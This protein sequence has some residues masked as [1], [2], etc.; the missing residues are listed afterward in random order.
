MAIGFKNI[1]RTPLGDPLFYDNRGFMF[2]KTPYACIR[3]WTN[4]KANLWMREWGR[5]K[6]AYEDTWISNTKRNIPHVK[7]TIPLGRPYRPGPHDGETC[8]LV[9]N[10][11][12]LR[13]NWQLLRG[14]DNIIGTNRIGL[15]DGVVPKY[16]MAIDCGVPSSGANPEW[17][18]SICDKCIGVFS[19]F[20][21][22]EMAAKFQRKWWF[23]AWG[24]N[25]ELSTKLFKKVKFRVAT[26]DTAMNV[27]YTAL[28]FA[29]NMGYSK[30]VLVGFDYA[31]TGGRFYW[32]DETPDMK[33]VDDNGVM[34]SK[35]AEMFF[36]N[37][38]RRF[39]VETDENKTVEKN[40]PTI[41][42]DEFLAA[43]HC[44][45]TICWFLNSA[46]IE[47]VNCT[48]SGLLTETPWI[49][50]DKL[51]NHVGVENGKENRLQRTAS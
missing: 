24:Q 33:F 8:Y 28:N 17:V 11:P 26:M 32:N 22:P 5:Q 19:V 23:D 49:K 10:G 18:D 16:Y 27:V 3:D 9:A 25:H 14:L 45:S 7:E 39:L 2:A 51:V 30:I 48:E 42:S 40:G 1:A 47:I 37:K 31:F 29:Y 50:C 41:T 44:F 38:W 21:R 46:G 36:H 12:G 34:L 13:N 4:P 35:K 15:M 20:V 43:K 6:S